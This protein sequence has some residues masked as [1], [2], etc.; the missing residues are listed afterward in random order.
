MAHP[1]GRRREAVGQALIAPA[2]QPNSTHTA[3]RQSGVFATSAPAS[4]QV[5]PGAG[6]ARR[7]HGRGP[8]NERPFRDAPA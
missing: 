2:S 8:P 6:L 7:R 3:P 4:A 5:P 1:P